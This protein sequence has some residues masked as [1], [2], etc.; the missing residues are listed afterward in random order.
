M[1]SQNTSLHESWRTA[2]VRRR[3]VRVFAA[4]AASLIILLAGFLLG[5][6]QASVT[7][8]TALAAVGD[9]EATVTAG[10]CS[11]G[12][13][14]GVQFWIDSHSGVHECGWPSC[15]NHGERP[16]VTIGAVP[17]SLPDGTSWPQV[18]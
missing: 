15:L 6:H 12:I 10:G 2:A 13:E 16:K 5:K 18:V 4:A 17:A 8:A 1:R 11:Y 14:G 9:R 7:V 3:A